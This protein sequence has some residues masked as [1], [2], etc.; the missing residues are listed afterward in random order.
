VVWAGAV[1]VPPRQ[2]RVGGLGEAD[3]DSEG[4]PPLAVTKVEGK[5]SG[6][7]SEK[8]GV[9]AQDEVGNV[10]VAELPHR[11]RVRA[12]RPVFFNDRGGFVAAPAVAQ[13]DAHGLAAGVGDGEVGVAV[14]GDVG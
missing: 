11:Q 5:L 1:K 6:L 10:V 12:G 7:V 4:E 3:S 2:G 9:V 14:A 13:V 8:A